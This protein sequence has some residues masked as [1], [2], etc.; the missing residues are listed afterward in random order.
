MEVRVIN[1]TE[2]KK[3][4][5]VNI[6][7]A[8]AVGGLGGYAIK[9]TLPLGIKEIND[10]T[11]GNYNNEIRKSASR[12]KQSELDA[13]RNYIKN[14]SKTDAMDMFLRSKSA[15]KEVAKQAR[16]EIQKSPRAVRAQ[17][18]DVASAIAKKVKLAAK[19]KKYLLD[20]GIKNDRPSSIF[21]VPGIALAVVSAFVYN[22]IGRFKD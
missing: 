17:I 11:G 22:V 1:N 4:Q 18:N 19:S 6:P 20:S 10:Y 15:D 14:K 9:H 5:K 16:K 13:L 3:A 21:I 7:I 12:A 2:P 8:A